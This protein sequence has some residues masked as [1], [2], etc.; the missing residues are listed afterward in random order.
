MFSFAVR[1]IRL[2]RLGVPDLNGMYSAWRRSMS[3]N[4]G[5]GGL[6]LTALWESRPESG[7]AVRDP[8]R[9]R[10]RRQRVCGVL[11]DHHARS[12][13]GRAEGRTTATLTVLIISMWT[14]LVLARPLT[15]WKLGLV[16]GMALAVAVIIAVPALGQGIFLLEVS[17]LRL[18]IAAIVGVAGAL[19]VELTH[20]SILILVRHAT[21]AGSSP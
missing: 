14:P 17:P 13:R 18:T 4:L 16:A 7:A 20:R 11:R 2:R 21:D 15:G 19:L 8:R 10:H 3:T 6:S 1:K 9:H 5:V 12:R